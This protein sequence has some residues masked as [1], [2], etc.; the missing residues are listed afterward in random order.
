M[1]SNQI[2]ARATAL[3]VSLLASLGIL[4]IACGGTFQGADDNGGGESGS[5]GS[6][7][8]GG[9]TT[10]GGTTSKGGAT[11]KAGSGQGGS[12]TTAGAGTG[13]AAP[14][15]P[16][17]TEPMVDPLTGLV[18]C[19]EGFT[20][21]PQPKQCEPLPVAADAAGGASGI[22]A[23]EP[24]L[25]RADG[26]VPCSEDPTVCQAYE[27]GYCDGAFLGGEAALPTC[28]SG[29]FNDV[30]CGS[31]S[32]CVC[33]DA[34]SPTGGV[35]RPSDCTSDLDCG[36]GLCASY[37]QVCGEG[38]F[39]C[40]NPADECTTNVDCMGGTCTF[41]SALGYRQCNN[42]VCGRPFLVEAE[43]RVAPIIE[44]GAWLE[45]GDWTPRT[46]H[47]TRSERAALAEHWMKMG[48]M[49]HASIAAFARFSLQ[50]LSLGAPPS[51]VQACTQALADETAHT[52]LCFQIA[53][54]YAGHAVG[55]G[56]LDVDRSLEVT[57]L[58]DIVDLVI[59]EGCFGETSAALEAL[60]SADSASDP[61]IRSAYAQIARD[62]QRHAELAF[63]FVRWALQQ[64]FAV[65]QRRI[66]AAL[67]QYD[68]P[69]AAV[70]SVVAPC[71]EALLLQGEA[72]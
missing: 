9:A 61:V 26:S 25:P 41:N 13:G 24:G 17:C 69:T 32:V 14:I 20:H 38:G 65:V 47:L 39:A 8:N 16:E 12:T 43:A 7:S 42:A 48:Q 64:D 72:A 62:E 51:L 37:Y 36:Y 6:S 2:G 5:G 44:S 66:M 53:S 67:T 22:A 29:C 63:Q 60:E 70:R 71:L 31:G 34:Q 49:E 15:G 59:A 10:K 55:P 33:G 18:T 68:A 3:R 56:P 28:K 58:E 45:R 46:D 54:V 23:P 4:H 50:L 19:K 40:H 52:R 27:Y 35:C 21:R 11:S 57:S 1:T 30:D